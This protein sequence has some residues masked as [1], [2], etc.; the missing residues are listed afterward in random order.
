MEAGSGGGNELAKCEC[1]SM[2]LIQR[3]AWL[4]FWGGQAGIQPGRAS[5][6]LAEFDAPVSKD[7]TSF[8]AHCCDCGGIAA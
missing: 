7:K 6:H 4:L 5:L 2:D 3:D 1:V 8:L